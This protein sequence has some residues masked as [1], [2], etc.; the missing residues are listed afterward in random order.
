MDKKS[1]VY[2]RTGDEGKTSLVGGQRVAKSEDKI[3]VYGVADELNSFIGLAL[4]LDDQK[5]EKEEEELL[6]KIQNNLFNLGSIL[7]TVPEERSKFNLPSVDLEIVKKLEISMDKMDSE[8]PKLKNFILPGGNIEASTFHVCRTVCRRL[9][10]LMARL[11][12]RDSLE[13]PVDCLTFVNRLS[14][15]FF[16]LSRSLNHRANVEEVIWK[17]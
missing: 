4:S 14:D 12:E 8:L 1:A 6:K 7:A 5:L 13:V 16:V 11:K 15:Y 10:R 17:P 9:E 3:E 2:T